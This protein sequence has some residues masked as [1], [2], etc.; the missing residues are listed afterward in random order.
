MKIESLLNEEIQSE[1]EE[2]KKMEVGTE[3]YDTAVNGLTKLID[4]TIEIDKLKAECEAKNEDR[5]TEADLR[6]TQMA[7]ERKDRLIK[8]CVSVAG[9]AI[10]SV[11]TIWGTLKALKFEETGTVTT[12]VGRGFINKL[13][14]KK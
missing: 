11:L 13:F 14:P 2:L 6:L 4:R 8:N 5:E 7:E 3:Q 12:I 1:F 10:P 9:I